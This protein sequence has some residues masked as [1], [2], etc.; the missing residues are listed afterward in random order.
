VQDF[1]QCLEDA[2]KYVILIHSNRM[3]QE[4]WEQMPAE[5]RSA[6]VAAYAALSADLEASGEVIASEALALPPLSK[7]ITVR[8]DVVS[9]TDGPFA[10]AKEYL[11]GF[12][13][14]DVADQQRAVEIAARIPEAR[15]GNVEVRPVMDLSAFEF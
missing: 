12:F 15:F 1:P 6:G 9:S 7:T 13:L 10:E 2:V 3:S 8:D 5:E 11:A 4:V 14:V